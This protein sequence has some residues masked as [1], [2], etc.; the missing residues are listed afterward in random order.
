MR[1]PDKWLTP[2]GREGRGCTT[3]VKMLGG[4][5]TPSPFCFSHSNNQTPHPHRIQ[6]KLYQGWKVIR[7]PNARIKG[8]RSLNWLH[9]LFSILSLLHSFCSI[10]VSCRSGWSSGLGESNVFFKVIYSFRAS[11]FFS[12]LW[13]TFVNTGKE[14]RA[15]LFFLSHVI[16]E[17]NIKLIAMEILLISQYLIPKFYFIVIKLW[18]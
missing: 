12:S 17:L 14:T 7:E 4:A 3:G 11:E 16:F 10:R 6:T 18:V 15:L 1:V 2:S 8:L 13:S 5:I 9:F